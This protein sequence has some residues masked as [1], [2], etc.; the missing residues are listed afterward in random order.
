M[1]EYSEAVAG[2]GFLEI[3]S[4]EAGSLIGLAVQRCGPKAAPGTCCLEK[5]ANRLC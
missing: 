2:F 5:R 4:G 1:N 3:P